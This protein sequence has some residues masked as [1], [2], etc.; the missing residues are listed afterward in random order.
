MIDI[1]IENMDGAETNVIVE[2]TVYV[3]DNELKSEFAENETKDAN[4]G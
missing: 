4:E 3:E 1:C 2:A